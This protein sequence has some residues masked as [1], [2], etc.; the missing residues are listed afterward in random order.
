VPHRCGV[1]RQE[2][3][4]GSHDSLSLRVL[5][6]AYQVPSRAVVRMFSA[7]LG[8]VDSSLGLTP[9]GATALRRSYEADVGAARIVRSHQHRLFAGVAD[10]TRWRRYTMGRHPVRRSVHAVR[11]I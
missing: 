9:S 10:A 1:Q 2:D 3:E 6:D 8:A 7:L 4:A 5:A 11:T